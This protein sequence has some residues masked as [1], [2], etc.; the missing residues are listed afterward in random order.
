MAE[1][2]IWGKLGDA[3][4]VEATANIPAQFDLA[5]NYPNPFNPSTMIKYSLKDLSDITLAIYNIR[6]QLIKT[7]I[8]R[9]QAAGN[10]EIQ[11]NATNEFGT[12]LASGLYF[13]KLH[14]RSQGKS[15]VKTRKMLLIK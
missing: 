15:I 3:T 11:W 2:Q 4:A 5:Q 8:H 7:L 1:L 14:A 9:R 13:Y 12:T 6:G 10:H